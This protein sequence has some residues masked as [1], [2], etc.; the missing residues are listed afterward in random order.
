M[1]I[2]LILALAVL[3]AKSS[4]ALGV[5]PGKATIH[6]E[7]GLE[8]TVDVEI[9]NND[10]KAFTGVIYV[11]GE[12]KDYITLS[13]EEIVFGDD[14]NIKSFSYTVSLPQEMEKPGVLAGD[15]KIV[16]KIDDSDENLNLRANVAVKTKIYL[17]IPYPGTYAEAEFKLSEFMKP[18]ENLDFFISV[19][20]LGKENI[21]KYF[22]TVEIYDPDGELIKS[23]TTEPKSVSKAQKGEL[24][25][26]MPPHSLPLGDYTVKAILSYDGK[27]LE[28]PAKPFRLEGSFIDLL[29]V[30]ADEY[31]LGS[32]AKFT[33]LLK[34]V[35]NRMVKDVFS[36][37][38]LNDNSDNVVAN[39]K[40]Y[41]VDLNKEETKE[42]V[43]YWDT[44]NI[45]IGEYHGKVN[46]NYEDEAFDREVKLMLEEDNIEVEVID[47]IS[48]MVAGD[49]VE[50]NFA[51]SSIIKISLFL[52]ITLLVVI[53]VVMLRKKKEN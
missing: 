42:V 20:N 19:F 43:A 32:V 4:S 1:I 15:I 22:A 38:V 2:L 41:S 53:L 34:N 27:T 31:S 21:K 8:K 39:I 5:S 50:T 18:E 28:L 35:G 48:G 37:M 3:S 46:V 36:R 26:S 17:N 6:F 49:Q 52:I 44:K 14:D 25:I 11:E 29:F 33:F 9:Y 30:I 16:Q 45:D 40:S 47:Q 13:T 51:D 12:L 7:P 10:N 24:V 23:I